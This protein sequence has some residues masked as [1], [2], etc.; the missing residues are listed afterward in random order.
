VSTRA[1]IAKEVDRYLSEALVEWSMIEP[2]DIEILAK[3]IA[4]EAIEVRSQ[5]DG[6]LISISEGAS[7]KP[8]VIHYNPR[9]AATVVLSA[10][11]GVAGAS[12]PWLWALIVLTGLIA[13]R[14]LQYRATPAESIL[15]VK[16][17]DSDGHSA[18]REDARDRFNRACEGVN[19]VSPE[20]F[21]VA[22]NGLMTLGC[23][24]E[25][26]GLIYVKETVII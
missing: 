11:A 8:Q 21:P 20:D 3:R 14:D 24:Q 16:L 12:I 13:L 18:T 10:V 23:V 7:N 26:D 1:Q 4:S 22:L 17:Y 25:A 19:G 5:A 6:K 9:A 2:A 15:F